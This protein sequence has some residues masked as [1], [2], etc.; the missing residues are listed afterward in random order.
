MGKYFKCFTDKNPVSYKLGEE[1]TFTVFAREDGKN[2]TCENVKW[3]MQGD[4]GG[5]V[6]G[7]AS[8]T[9]SKP[10]T[11]KYTLKRAGFVHL[12]CV[13]MG[14]NGEEI[15]DFEPLDSS[16]GVNVLELAY[17]DT[18]PED[19]QNYWAEIEKTVADFQIELEYFKEK[20]D[21]KREGFKEYELRVKTPWGRPASGFITIPLGG[22]KYSIRISFL[23]YGVHVA[24]Y[25]YDENMICGCFNAHGFENGYWEDIEKKYS[26]ELA[27]YGF[28]NE[29][30]AS[31]KNTYFRNMMVRNLMALKYMKSLPEWN[32]KDILS[33]G[34]SQGALQ[35]I[36]VAAHDKDVTEVM[37]YKPWFC[38]LNSV[39]EGYLRGWR[40][41]F[42]EGLRYF[43]TVAQ[44]MQLKCPITIECYLGDYV[45]PPKTVMALYNSIKSEKSIK[46]IQSARHSYFPP[47]NEEISADF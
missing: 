43:D 12:N 1:I 44:A 20:E 41:D 47:E 13:A 22:E 6:K 38:D 17:S 5:I 28:N 18:L 11:V 21:N 16:A 19:F 4:D 37:A 36:T 34:G 39:N 35:A 33:V 14:E 32:G 30:N 7:F 10:L 45:C 29:E 2:I 8:I 9:E 40:P 23:G 15:K 31:N 42:A 46:F 27:N 26:K 25:E 3:E 24:H